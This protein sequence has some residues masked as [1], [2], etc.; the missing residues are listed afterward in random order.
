M[1]ASFSPPSVSVVQQLNCR[2]HPHVHIRST[3]TFF[4]LSPA[5]HS[6]QIER[7]IIELQTKIHVRRERS[8][9]SRHKSHKPE[10]ITLLNLLSFSFLRHVKFVQFMYKVRARFHTSRQK[11]PTFLYIHGSPKTLPLALHSSLP[12]WH[13]A[14]VLTKRQW[15][16]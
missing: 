1:N 16:P 6:E 13:K 14:L 11:L 5:A 15:H 3:F 4:Q 10:N 7:V 9:V 2:R 8:K 12:S